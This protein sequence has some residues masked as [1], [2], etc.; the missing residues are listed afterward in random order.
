[1][2]GVDSQTSLGSRALRGK[3]DK[4][5]VLKK[6]KIFFPHLT[7]SY[8]YSLNYS[9][10]RLVSVYESPCLENLSKHRSQSPSCACKLPEY[11]IFRGNFG[12]PSWT[13]RGSNPAGGEIFSTRPDRPWGLPSLLYNGYRVIPGGKATGAWL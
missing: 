10:S 2:T 9:Y 13:V 11:Y 4:V 12:E 7:A 6:K 5:H 8:F 3:L 1:M